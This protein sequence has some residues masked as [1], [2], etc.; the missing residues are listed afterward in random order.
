MRW[1]ITKEMN[2][3]NYSLK[4]NNEVDYGL[5]E[6]KKMET[7]KLMDMVDIER[8]IWGKVEDGCCETNNTKEK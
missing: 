6:M 1:T 2:E 4:K 8:Y 5:K 3:K 7:V